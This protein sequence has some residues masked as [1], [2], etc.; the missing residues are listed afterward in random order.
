MLKGK[1]IT[2]LAMAIQ[3]NAQRKMDAVLDS[4][5]IRVVAT[6]DEG[7]AAIE[8]K[9]KNGVVDAELT[10]HAL[11]QI[12]TH[13]GVPANYSDRMLRE[14][15]RLLEH[16][17]NHWL[18]ANP[19]L[20]MVRML[21]PATKEGPR[22]ARAFLSN[23]YQ[24]IDFERMLA[25]TLPTL[26]EVGVRVLSTEL[27]ERRMYI[28][29]V[30]PGLTGAV[31]VGD[32]VE[33]GFELRGSEIGEGAMEILPFL[34]QLWCTNGAVLSKEIDDTRLRR[35]HLGR[36]LEEGVE[37]YSEETEKAA[38]ELILLKLRDTLKAM[39]DKPRWDKVL[40]RLQAAAVAGGPVANPVAAIE[41]V[42]EMF[43]LPKPEK[44]GILEAFI[45][46]K[47]YT[48]WGLNSA[49][50]WKANSVD[51][52][53]RAADLEDIGARVLTLPAND[54]SRLAKAA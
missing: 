19:T 25:Y 46:G 53:D 7:K 50:T 1:S 33:Y 31:K 8:L 45:S 10:G 24:R 12:T 52:Y 40:A 30:F 28:K 4:R 54:W 47:D 32:V 5:N 20:R 26:E 13:T 36:A 39:T 51:S 6:G 23:K 43:V 18:N 34:H 17:I 37:Y 48:R 35:A 22:V 9:S 38:D 27:T 42:A 44:D 21:Q 2:E 15:P 14:A 49:I 16:N 11:R 3:A 41:A 29:A